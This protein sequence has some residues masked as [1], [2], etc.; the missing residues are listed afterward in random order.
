MLSVS[1]KS[2]LKSLAFFNQLLLKTVRELSKII[3]RN[4]YFPEQIVKYANSD[5]HIYILEEGEIGFAC[6][7]PDSSLNRVTVDTVKRTEKS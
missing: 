5:P 7:S 1:N 6:H 2:L 4:I 3:E